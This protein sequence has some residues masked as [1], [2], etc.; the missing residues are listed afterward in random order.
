MLEFQLE[1]ANGT[2]QGLVKRMTSC[3]AVDLPSRLI[4]LLGLAPL[5]QDVLKLDHDAFEDERDCS[6]GTGQAQGGTGQAQGTSVGIGQ[7]QDQKAKHKEPQSAQW[8]R[9]ADVSERSHTESTR[10]PRVEGHRQAV[11]Q[12]KSLFWH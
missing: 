1:K 9:S 12:V 10:P 8:L 11:L 4:S 2:L 6:S 5:R 3:V 7:A